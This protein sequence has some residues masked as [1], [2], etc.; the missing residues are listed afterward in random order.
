[1]KKG[2]WHYKKNSE[3]NAWQKLTAQRNKL[4]DHTLAL[5]KDREALAEACKRTPALNDSLAILDAALNRSR[6]A[7]RLQAERLMKFQNK[8][9]DL[10][11]V[12]KVRAERKIS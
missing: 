2:P 9:A 6:I 7:Y 1:M 10:V 4:H 5:A 11:R 8:L 3:N 12:R